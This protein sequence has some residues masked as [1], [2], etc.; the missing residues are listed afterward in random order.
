MPYASRPDLSIDLPF[1]RYDHL[2]RVDEWRIAETGMALV[3]EGDG[4]DELS[5]DPSDV[6][7]SATSDPSGIDAEV[8]SRQQALASDP[9]AS[10]F[11]SANAGTGKT[12]L[13]TDRVLRLMLEGAPPDS[14]LCVTYTRAAAAEMRN[15]ISA[16]LAKWT[17]MTAEELLADLAGMGIAVAS[18]AVQ[19]RARS[20][21]AEI[22]DN[23]DGP[24]VETVHSF[25]QSVLRRFPI[26]AGIVPHA[27]LADDIEQARLKAQAR[28][29]IMRRADPAI[30]LAIASLAEQTSE[31]NAEDLLNSLMRDDPRLGEVDILA[32]LD[33]HFAEERGI[34]PQLD[35]ARMMGAALASLDVE[36]LRA[37]ATALEG[38]GKK[39]YV[40]RGAQITRWLGES[41]AGRRRGVDP[42]D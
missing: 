18:Q 33:R 28:D 19:Q 20:L 16:K 21:F 17:V 36:G 2:A 8:V 40:G 15:R 35:V 3:D 14:I 22:L 27:E 4:G 34:D 38:S 23:D 24:R 11:V 7:A 25:C 1:A 30:Q 26:E 10:V 29:T 13:L 9:N 41:E 32:M 39:N 42:A 6:A 5:S 37:T 31:G 12:K